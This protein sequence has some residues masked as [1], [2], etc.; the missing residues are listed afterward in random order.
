MAIYH[1]NI[2][3]TGDYDSSI[4]VYLLSFLN[5]DYIKDE[6]DCYKQCN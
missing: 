4:I 6:D 5:C 2:I 3:K 1:N